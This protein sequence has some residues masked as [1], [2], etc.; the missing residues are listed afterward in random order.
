MKIILMIT[1]FFLT[2]CSSTQGLSVYSLNNADLEYVIA[3]RL[4]A[5]SKKL[6]IMGLPVQFDVNALKVDIGP[7]DRDV[8]AL[9]VDSSA[10]INAF[11]LKY[12]VRLTLQ[13]EGSPFY[14]SKKKAI[15]LRDIKLLNSSINAGDFKGNL[16]IL[17]KQ[18]MT[19]LNGFLAKNPVY[20]LNTKDPKMAL[21]SKLPLDIKVVKGAIK[22]IPRL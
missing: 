1:A 4:P 21:L 20:R 8:V 12:P 11:L 3:E 22:V 15:F 17:N 14:D 16:S 13:I 10:Q 19:I 2:A 5:L 6:S 9:G 7:D 18:A